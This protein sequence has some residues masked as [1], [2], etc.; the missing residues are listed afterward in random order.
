MWLLIEVPVIA[1]GIHVA[2]ELKVVVPE[3]IAA[4]CEKNEEGNGEADCPLEVEGELS[5]AV[6]EV[7]EERNPKGHTKPECI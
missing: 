6:T 4:V 1:G 7:E 5:K 2:I 3:L